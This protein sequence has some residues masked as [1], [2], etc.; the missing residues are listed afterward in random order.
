MLVHP[1]NGNNDWNWVIL[2]PELFLGCLWVQKQ[3]HLVMDCLLF[4]AHKQRL[5]SK[6][7][8]P[9]YCVFWKHSC[10]IIS[11][12]AT[13]LDPCLTVFCCRC[14]CLNPHKYFIS[15]CQGFYTVS[16]SFHY[17]QPGSKYIPFCVNAHGLQGALLPPH[18]FFAKFHFFHDGCSFLSFLHWILY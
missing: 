4:Q 17:F 7:G 6:A 16:E 8:Q 5:G 11:F 2:M 12:P 3:K 9:G 13:L 18:I 14:L 15:V 1:L 10:L